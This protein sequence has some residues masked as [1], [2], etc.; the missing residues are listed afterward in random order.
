[1]IE[2]EI[3]YNGVLERLGESPAVALL[4]PRQVGKTTLALQVAES[5]PSVYLDLESP[6]DRNKLSDP[7]LYRCSV[8]PSSV[9]VGK[10][11]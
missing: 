4:A 11:F 1:M 2:R 5:R 3:L 10:A 8:T 7:K 9:P 6:A